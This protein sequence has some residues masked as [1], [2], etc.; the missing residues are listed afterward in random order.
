MKCSVVKRHAVL[1]CLLLSGLLLGQIQV[2]KA[3]AE[4]YEWNI[5]VDSGFNTYQ[6][7]L[8]IFNNWRVN[9][10]VDMVFRLNLSSKHSSLNHTKTKWAKITIGS[11]AAQ[12]SMRSETQIETVMLANVGDYWEREVSFYIPT[13]MLNRGQTANVSVWYEVCIEHVFVEGRNRIHVGDNISDL[14]HFCLYRPILSTLE[15]TV[16]A[17]VIVAIGGFILYRRRKTS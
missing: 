3:L 16:V 7:S 2:V 4:T 15:V 6:I 10:T 14:M 12:L 8:T 11:E 9:R 1:S 5:P 17:I 13:D